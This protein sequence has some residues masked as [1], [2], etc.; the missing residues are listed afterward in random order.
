MLSGANALEISDNSREWNCCV[1]QPD[2][3]SRV[4]FLIYYF[5]IN[6]NLVDKYSQCVSGATE[7]C[8]TNGRARPEKS[9]RWLGENLVSSDRGA[10]ESTGRNESEP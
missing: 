7:E 4:D 1:K 5:R 2:V 9:P 3:Y 8:G 6:S 10:S